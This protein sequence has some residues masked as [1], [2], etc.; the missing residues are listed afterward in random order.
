MISEIRRGMKV[1][2]MSC[3]EPIEIS[4]D[5]F[6]LDSVG[7]YIICLNCGEVLDVQSYLWYGELVGDVEND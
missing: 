6:K 7:E 2:C 1:K 4:G 3:G 5:T